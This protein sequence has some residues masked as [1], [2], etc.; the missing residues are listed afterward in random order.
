MI[1]EPRELDEAEEKI[2]THIAED[3]EWCEGTGCVIHDTHDHH[4]EHRE[5]KMPCHCQLG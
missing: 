4:G 3:C 2:R 1:D 5:D